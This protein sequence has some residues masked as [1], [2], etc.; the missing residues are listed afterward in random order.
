MPTQFV[1]TEIFIQ[2][3]NVPSIAPITAKG[4]TLTLWHDS[5][6]T[7]KIR[8][9]VP[10]RKSVSFPERDDAELKTTPGRFLRAVTFEF[11]GTAIDPIVAAANP[12]GD[13]EDV[14]RLLNDFLNTHVKDQFMVQ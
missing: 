4:V 6:P 14:S 3:P 10:F 12:K 7:L 13:L 9:K 8:A 1:P 11:C 2:G 5:V